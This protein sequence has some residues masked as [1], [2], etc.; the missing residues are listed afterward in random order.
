MNKVSDIE[1]LHRLLYE[2]CIDYTAYGPTTVIDTAEIVLL[3]MDDGF[4]VFG[5]GYTGT[6][7]YSAEYVV[8]MLD[9]KFREGMGV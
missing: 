4:W 5:E 2:A 1:K 6:W 9:K 7:T 3:S 8:R